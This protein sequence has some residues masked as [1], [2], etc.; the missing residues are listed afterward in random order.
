MGEA[1]N[2]TIDGTMG[3]GP[4]DD[5]AVSRENEPEPAQ[6]GMP[7]RNDAGS[8]EQKVRK[9]LESLGE[10]LRKFLQPVADYIIR[11]SS[12]DK[13]M[14]ED[15]CREHKTLARLNDHLRKEARAYASGQCVAV[16]DSVVF[17]WAE[18]YYRMDDKAMEEKAKKEKKE[19]E[20]KVTESLP[21][22]QT[23]AEEKQTTEKKTAKRK[24]A[25]S[26]SG[27]AE[28][29]DASKVKDAKEKSVS[30]MKPAKKNELDGQMSLFDLMGE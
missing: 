23:G 12:E 7:D 14:A 27:K 18:D 25:A 15:V 30:E 2:S 17:E 6:D 21:Q 28:K 10:S 26:N 3:T 5:G 13:G 8:A 11:R 22:E 9:E 20:K 19:K 1:L 24:D 4:G 29:K 16:P